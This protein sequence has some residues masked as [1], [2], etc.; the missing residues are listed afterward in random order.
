M[1]RRVSK[2]HMPALLTALAAFVLR[3]RISMFRD[4][5]ADINMPRRETYGAQPPCEL[6][7]Q[8]IDAQGLYDRDGLFWKDIE[9]VV[10][11]AACGP[12]GGGRQDMSPRL[13][14]H[15]ATLAIPQASEAAMASIMQPILQAFLADFPAEVQDMCKPLVA[16]TVEG[17]AR[18]AQELLPTPAKSHYTFNFRDVAKVVAG[19]LMIR[20]PQCRTREA[21]VRLWMHEFL[22]VFHDRCAARLLLHGPRAACARKS[23]IN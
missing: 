19:M 11:C 4:C 9:G 14:R 8:L 3:P 1:V 17:Y 12:P 15:F 20:S 5:H 2:R 7:R 18:V 10:V 13:V 16:A 22:R 23:K 21:V 6:L